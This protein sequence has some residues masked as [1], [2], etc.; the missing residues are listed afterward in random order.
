LA[1]KPTEQDT[2][3]REVDEELRRERV[4]TFF[5]RYT[6]HLVAAV[7]LFL[8]A[9]GGVIWWQN[10]EQANRGLEG[11]ALLEA[12]QKAE[13][14]NRPASLAKAQ[15]ISDSGADGYRVA[16]SFLK[17]SN[18]AE[19]GNA[20]A[21]AATLRAIAEDE[22]LAEPYRQAALIR[23]TLLEYDRLQPQA[24]IQRLGPLA[25]PGQPWFGTAGELVAIAHLRLRQNDRAGQ[26]FARIARD[27]TVPSS[28]RTRAVQMAGSLGINAMPANA[29]AD[30]AAAVAPPATRD[31]S[32]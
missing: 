31:E 7:V 9:I 22:D 13:V 24:V 20:A 25:R 2:F 4:N 18:E 21:A 5:A 1:I 26:L 19:A 11:E 8:A 3:L 16:A 14:G 12:I 10:K 27:E 6:W 28:I 23:Q 32:E 30:P 29:G 17:A 15:E